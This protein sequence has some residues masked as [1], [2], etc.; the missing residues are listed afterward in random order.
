MSSRSAISA[1]ILARSSTIF[2]RSSAARR[3]SC[4]SRMACAW[5]SSMSSSS[6]RPCLATSTVSD[7]R[8][9]AIARLVLDVGDAGQLAVA[10]LLGDRGDE[11][12]VIDLIR[13]LGD[14]DAGPAPVVLFDLA[15]AAHP[16]RPATGGV[17]VVDA[18]GADNQ[19]VRRE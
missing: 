10:D 15:H 17:R 5:M 18:L 7:A 6:I 14:D 16:D 2:W 1:S 8:I 4:M 9:D 11:V 3:R 19:A 12:V 13:Q